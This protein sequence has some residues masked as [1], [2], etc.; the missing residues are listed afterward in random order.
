[1]SVH[2]L[3]AE[4]GAL[5]AK[6]LDLRRSKLEA[7]VSGYRNWIARTRR[8][9]FPEAVVVQKIALV[10]DWLLILD[11]KLNNVKRQQDRFVEVHKL[12]K[13]DKDARWKP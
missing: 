1:M 7:R 13:N 5:Q 6:N 4:L 12:V 10:E 11:R 3:R 2:Y 8:A 9:G